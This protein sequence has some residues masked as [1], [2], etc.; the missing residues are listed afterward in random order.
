MGLDQ[1]N[2]TNVNVTVGTTSINIS[3]KKKRK[4]VYIR[5]ISTG[6][7]VVT[8]AL[9]NVNVAVVGVGVVLSPGEYFVESSSDGY[10]AWTGDIKAVASAAEAMV[11]IMELPEDNNGI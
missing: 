6:A 9:D 5:N 8:I 4:T 11:S 1:K 10:N 3:P 2:S 7:Q